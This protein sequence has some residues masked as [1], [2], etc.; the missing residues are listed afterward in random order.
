MVS[1]KDLLS[2][3]LE[4][5]KLLSQLI[6][7]ELAGA[8]IGIIVTT[9]V[10]VAIATPEIATKY[11]ITAAIAALKG[12]SL[13]DLEYLVKERFEITLGNSWAKSS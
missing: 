12:Q 13:L 5:P 10:T 1:Q 3:R 7:P 11:F 8:S 6:K 4:K 9:A 2:Q